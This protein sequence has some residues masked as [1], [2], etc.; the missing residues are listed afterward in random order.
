MSIIKSLKKLL[1]NL[2]GSRAVKAV[3]SPLE[4][5]KK[6][7]F[8]DVGAGQEVLTRTYP[9]VKRKSLAGA[10]QHIANI[11]KIRGEQL[12]ALP[13]V[14]AVDKGNRVFL[15]HGGYISEN[16]G[17]IALRWSKGP[18]NPL[19]PEKYAQKM[20]PIQR[21]PTFKSSKN[22]LDQQGFAES[23]KRV[24]K[25]RKAQKNLAKTIK[26]EGM[27]NPTFL[28]KDIRYMFE[29]RGKYGT[30]FQKNI[31]WN[32]GAPSFKR[33]LSEQGSIV[34]K[35]VD[36]SF[37]GKISNPKSLPDSLKAVMS[38]D[39]AKKSYKLRELRLRRKN[40]IINNEFDIT[41]RAGEKVDHIVEAGAQNEV[42]KYFRRL[43][44]KVD[45]TVEELT[46]NK[47]AIQ[48]HGFPSK[49]YTD[50]V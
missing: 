37:P 10:R 35:G 26:R 20:N 12:K 3:T 40:P 15:K 21:N 36:T 46:I 39:T 8:L 42:A 13:D 47:K 50:L 7:I 49:S 17:D 25:A 38:P 2:R 44:G 43:K 45:N 1:G 34:G 9:K 23:S 14:F 41:N 27:K 28:D 18:I 5:G 16:P 4:I 22:I 30:T 32:R 33:I 11:R 48:H 19:Q 6:K 31:S 29:V 24:A